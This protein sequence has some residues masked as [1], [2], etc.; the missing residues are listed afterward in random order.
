MKWAGLGAM[1]LGAGA[2][3]YVGGG[4]LVQPRAPHLRHLSLEETEILTAIADTMFPG[5]QQPGGMPAASEVGI[6]TFFDDYLATIDPFA[7][8]ALRVALHV[9]D[10]AA[11][12]ADFGARR[13][14]DRPRAEREEILRAWE[15]SDWSARRG[16]F[17]GVKIL[18]SM[19]YTEHPAVI[20]AAGWDY[21]CGNVRLPAGDGVVRRFAGDEGE[22]RG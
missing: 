21:G 16:T 1:A 7:R 17:S 5:E 13:F 19:G 8:K 4:W 10:D 11:I 14:R 3:M 20:A 2:S 22:A 12:L 15:Q 9:I 18:I 6:V